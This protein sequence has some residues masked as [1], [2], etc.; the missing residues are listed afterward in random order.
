MGRASEYGHLAGAI[1]AECECKHREYE[2]EDRTRDATSAVAHTPGP[3][4]AAEPRHRLTIIASNGLKVTDPS[5]VAWGVTISSGANRRF[6]GITTKRSP[7]GSRRFDASDRN[8][9]V[10][11]PV[12]EHI[13]EE[14]HT[15]YV[16]WVEP[17]GWLSA[18]SI[19]RS[20]RR[21]NLV[22]RNEARQMTQAP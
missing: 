5:F 22:N 11:Q 9:P 16:P 21:M 8:P 10:A 3:I 14:R 19:P 17:R 20:P 1:R 12:T 13:D 2:Q 18:R 6:A 15:E 4:S 7:Q